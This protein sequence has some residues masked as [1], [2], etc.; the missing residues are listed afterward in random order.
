MSTRSVGCT[1]RASPSPG[2]P[3]GTRPPLSKASMTTFRSVAH[4]L[5]TVR[6]QLLGLLALALA[7]APASAAA[8]SSRADLPPVG[9]SRILSVNPL[10]LVFVGSISA[11]YEQ[12]VASSVSLGASVSS[13]DLSKANYFTVEGRA[14]YYLS[15][16]ALDGFA[17]GTSLGVVNMSA[18]DT[19]ETATGLS[20]GFTVE[21]QWLVGPEERLALA[22][23]AGASRLF[24]TGDSD[25]FKTVLPSLRL[26]LGWG[27]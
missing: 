13:F 27:F 26:S 24:G 1:R 18:D 5:R 14:R 7:V 16:R 23:G 22:A 2:R 25:V 21:H 15:G 4:V 11:D 6:P 3:D 17:V 20:I 10:L 19:T 8:Q 9:H 12:R